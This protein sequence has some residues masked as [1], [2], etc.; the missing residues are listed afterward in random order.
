MALYEKYSLKALQLGM[1]EVGMK[2]ESQTIINTYCEL[3]TELSRTNWK[4]VAEK[5]GM[6]TDGHS[7][8]RITSTL[9]AAAVAYRNLLYAPVGYVVRNPED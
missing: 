7:R 4:Q 3:S 9:T 6:P 1:K 5:L 2:Q 8:N